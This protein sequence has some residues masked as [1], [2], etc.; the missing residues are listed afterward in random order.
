MSFTNAPV[1]RTIVSGVI[2]SSVLGSLLD[3][4]HYLY[5]LTD[6]HIW[7]YHQLWR[8][9]VFQLGYTNSSEALFGAIAFYHMRTIERLWGSRKYAVRFSERGKTGGP[10][11]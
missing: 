4:K 6:L 5:I 11:Q 8:V 10:V 3:L 1:T 7:Q 2:L 9:F